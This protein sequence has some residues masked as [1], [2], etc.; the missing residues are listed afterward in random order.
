MGP[1]QG[2]IHVSLVINNSKM[3]RQLPNS[4]EDT[5]AQG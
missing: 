3:N 5:L 1:A 4:E 2:T